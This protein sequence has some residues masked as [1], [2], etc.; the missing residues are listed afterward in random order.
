MPGGYGV[1]LGFESPEKLLVLVIVAAVMFAPSR[2]PELGRALGGAIRAFRGGLSETEGPP[3]S[4]S[5]VAE[6]E[7]DR[8]AGNP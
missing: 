7:P 5:S 6:A 8:P 2:L 1:G 4:A 3:S